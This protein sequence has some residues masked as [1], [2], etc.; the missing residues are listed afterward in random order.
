[1]SLLYLLYLEFE[2]GTRIMKK[3]KSSQVNALSRGAR[4][5]GRQRRL[6]RTGFV[7]VEGL[8]LGRY[9]FRAAI[10]IHLEMIR[11]G[12]KRNTIEERKR[13]LKQFALIFEGFK[14][15]GEITTTD[16][17]K[18]ERKA[19]QLFMEWLKEEVLDP[20]SQITYLAHLS[21]FLK[22]FKNFII[23]EMKADGF[24][25]P[26]KP[27]KPIKALS[28]EEIRGLIGGTRRMKGWNASVSK[29][30]LAIYLATGLRVSELRLAHIEDLTLEKRRFYVRVPK[31]LGSYANPTT[32]S[33]LRPELIP[34]I[35]SYLEERGEYLE[36]R[37][38]ESAIPLFPHYEKGEMKFYSLSGLNDMKRKLEEVTG[39]SFRWKD[40][41]PTHAW[42]EV[43]D[44]LSRL[45]AVQAQLRHSSPDTTAR[46]YAKVDRGR[47]VERQ[48]GEVWRENP[49]FPHVNPVI[50][51]KSEPTGYV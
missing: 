5:A 51:Q 15:K 33:I 46:F 8:H 16:P 34:Q 21:A 31:G 12:V 27:N 25:F 43:N 35:E 45:N 13:K 10:P 28:M 48:L 38:F 49:I 40:L 2:H 3:E 19:I 11:G 26:R 44:D 29:G 32:I 30:L 14:A 1:L 4:N 22:T 42:L 24:R 23:E 7:E 37:G 9:P 6:G 36:K 17:R 41:R 20:I 47:A 50:D 39:I 18:L